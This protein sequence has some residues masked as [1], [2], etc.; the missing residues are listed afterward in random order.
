MSPLE[1]VHPQPLAIANPSLGKRRFGC[2]GFRA[3]AKLSF[4]LGQTV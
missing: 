2:P 3:M 1:P 4:A